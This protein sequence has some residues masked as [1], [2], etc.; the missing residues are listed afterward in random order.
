MVDHGRVFSSRNIEAATVIGDRL[1]VCPLQIQASLKFDQLSPRIKSVV[2]VR[3][4]H[5]HGFTE[6]AG[7]LRSVRPPVFPQLVHTRDYYSVLYI[8]IE[9]IKSP[10]SQ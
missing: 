1:L 8:N 2:N 4:G 5:S 3:D 7:M 9:V 6:Y 10:V